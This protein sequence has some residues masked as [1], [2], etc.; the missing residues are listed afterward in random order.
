[1]PSAPVAR[2]ALLCR[3][4]PQRPSRCPPR[5][6]LPPGVGRHLPAPDCATAYCPACN[7]RAIISGLSPRRAPPD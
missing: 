6:R 7:V 2:H 1:M 5:T 4:Q 3:C